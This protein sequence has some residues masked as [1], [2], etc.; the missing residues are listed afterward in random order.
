MK[1][2]AAFRSWDTELPVTGRF[3]YRFGEQ[4]SGYFE[5]GF[6]YRVKLGLSSL[7]RPPSRSRLLS[8]ELT[9][10]PGGGLVVWCIGGGLL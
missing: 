4:W 1:G 9:K 3:R 2:S 10:N 7:L 6:Q 5:R 8:H